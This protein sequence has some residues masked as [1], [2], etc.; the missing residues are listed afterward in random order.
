M[1]NVDIPEVRHRSIPQTENL[2]VASVVLP[3]N[4]R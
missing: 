3:S 1:K 4:L 2:D